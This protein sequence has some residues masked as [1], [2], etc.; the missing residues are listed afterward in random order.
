MAVL[1]IITIP[2]ERLLKV[3]QKVS[4][5]DEETK[6]IVQNLKDTLNNAK[7]PEGAGL[8]APQ[9]GILQRIILVRNFLPNPSNRRKPVIQEFALI[10]PRIISKSKELQLDWEG[11]LSV[12]D[13][14][15][16]VERNY[17]IK[18]RAQDEN[19]DE[20]KINVSGLF[21]QIIQHEIDHLDGILFT[22][23]VV[24]ETVN[25]KQ[26]DK[27]YEQYSEK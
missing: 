18:V 21:A 27:I 19:G 1:Q 3:C 7:N 10:N 9:I 14:Y 20:I 11:C 5:F 25:E 13:T 24:G 22:T 26:L 16:R 12:P 4:H 15:G 23:K 2:D 6:Q 8:A 17:K